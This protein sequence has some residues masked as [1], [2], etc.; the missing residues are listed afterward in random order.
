[1]KCLLITLW[2]FSFFTGN[3]QNEMLKIDVGIAEVGNIPIGKFVSKIEYVPLELTE[4][5]ALNEAIIYLTDKYIVTIELFDKI[6]LFDR[7]DGSFVRNV[8]QKGNGPDDY[9]YPIMF[10][11]IDKENNLLYVET[12]NA[13]RGIDIETNKCVK[14]IIKPRSRYSKSQKYQNYIRNIYPYGPDLYIGFANNGRSSRFYELYI[15]D[16]N[17]VVQKTIN[18]GGRAFPWK[19]KETLSDYGQF[20]KVNEDL[21]FKAAAQNDTVYLVTE[22]SLKPA[23]VLDLH[24]ERS[25]ELYLYS[26]N[27][28]QTNRYVFF[29]CGMHKKGD[30]SIIQYSNCYDKISNKLYACK[31]NSNRSGFVN[32]IDGVGTLFVQQLEGN[33]L[34]G[35][36]MPEELLDYMET[37][38]DVKLSSTGKKILENLQFD[39]NPIVVIATLKE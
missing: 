15:F 6:C 28:M 38:K 36:L 5:S 17:G 3:A 1:M 22:S 19:G 24:K 20:Q 26:S 27:V 14:E 32:D 12:W 29:N 39:D 25:D 11:A 31:I 8:S 21:F 10:N 18:N 13:W 35:L 37:H 16:S 33:K 30:V 23:I 9:L 4:N 2:I 34:V 7:K